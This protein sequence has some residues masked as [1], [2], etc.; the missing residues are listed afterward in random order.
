ME[1]RGKLMRLSRNH[2]SR[3]RGPGI[4]SKWPLGQQPHFSGK[5][6]DELMRGLTLTQNLFSA[7]QEGIVL[8]PASRRGCA[9]EACGRHVG[10]L[11]GRSRAFSSAGV[12][13]R[14]Y[15]PAPL[16]PN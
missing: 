9:W 15:C 3:K 11:C 4:G 2:C 14:G 10:D 16:E 12:G 13:G 7:Y 6:G 5:S 1:A 8:Y